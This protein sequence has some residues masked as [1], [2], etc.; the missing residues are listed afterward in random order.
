MLKKFIRLA[1]LS[2][3]VALAV[4]MTAAYLVQTTDADQT[5]DAR[6]SAL[7]YDVRDLIDANAAQIQS[8]RLETDA[9]YIEKTRAFAEMIKLKPEIL[10]DHDELIRIRDLMHVDELHVC[11]AE[12]VLRWGTIKDFYGF[13]FATSDQTRPILAALD[14]PNFELAQDPQVSGTGIYFQY[15]SVSR[16]D[17]KGIVQ[18]GMRPER[19]EEALRRAAPENILNQ[20]KTDKSTR[21]LLIANGTIVGDCENKLTGRKLS[22]IGAEITEGIGS[23]NLGVDWRYNAKQNEDYLIA[24]FAV[25]SDMYQARNISLI[26]Y[27]VTNTLILFS[28]IFVVGWCMTRNI[29]KP[30]VVL[31]TATEELA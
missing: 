15:I 5:T 23:V 13:D 9:V 24:A 3:V 7:L 22:E 1:I 4:S 19:L 20:I 11:D 31:S 27:F 18:I 16:Y 25:K 26:V 10:D 2:F 14:N 8:I 21:L 29:I 6:L 30:I 17:E 12:G 28:L